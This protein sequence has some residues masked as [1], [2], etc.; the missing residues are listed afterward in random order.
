[1]NLIG[2]I[3]YRQLVINVQSIIYMT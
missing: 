2:Y 3:K 1:L